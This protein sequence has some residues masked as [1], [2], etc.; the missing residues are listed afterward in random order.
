MENY[1]K[2]IGFMKRKFKRPQIGLAL[3]AGGPRGLAHIGVLKVLE[4]NGISIDCLA[5][6]SMGSLIGALY[7]AGVEIARLEEI[8]LNVDLKQTAVMLTPTIPRSGLVEGKRMKEFI[9]SFVG[10]ANIEDLEI[11][12]AAVATDIKTGE[13]IVID[14]GS[15]AEAVRASISIPGIFTPARF[16]D[17]F[18][19]DGG[20]S[21]PVPVSEVRQMGAD[22]I[23]AVN[24]IASIERNAQRIG[25]GAEAKGVSPIS[26]I[27]SK[28]VN[29]Q[30]A[31]YIQSKTK[32]SEIVTRIGDIFG[33]DRSA[34][35]L[36]SSPSIFD[37]IFQ[38]IAI[39]EN[40]ILSLRLKEDKPDVLISPDVGFLKPLE[41]YRAKEAISAGER[42]TKDALPE[43]KQML[44]KKRRFRWKRII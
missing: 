13:E 6:S 38:M 21:N 16:G 42:A 12:F 27:N 15:V 18:L 37:V 8:A 20:L 17:R 7:A 1:I 33:Q 34:K 2:N 35:K 44:S 29:S 36:P 26:K 39:M 19:V 10:D 23:I 32:Q 41:Y 30:I 9:K 22:V 24:V 11:P 40:E 43:I 4:E 5:G 28:I 31:K 3:G 25:I 14:N